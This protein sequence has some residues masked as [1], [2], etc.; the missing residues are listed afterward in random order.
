MVECVEVPTW[1]GGPAVRVLLLDGAWQEP[2][3]VEY[4]EQ[5]AR[6][7]DWEGKRRSALSLAPLR[8]LPNLAV[9]LVRAKSI[10]ASALTELPGLARLSFWG[11][12][13]VDADLSQHR[14]L[15]HLFC[16]DSN[17]LRSALELPLLENVEADDCRF[18]DLSAV[19]ALPSLSTLRLLSRGSLI[20]LGQGVQAKRLRRL[21]LEDFVFSGSLKVSGMPNLQDVALLGAAGGEDVMDVS[22]LAACAGLRWLRIRGPRE[23]IGL[24]ALS[25][26]PALEAVRVVSAAVPDAAT[27]ALGDRLALL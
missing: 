17:T 12:I 3:A 9:A 11:D 27:I 22:S 26:L 4:A 19:A 23:V 7:V 1:D 25:D 2:W 16:P 20:D 14:D 21:V 18:E 6:G 24:E 13:R 5:G 8:E 15:R 10:D